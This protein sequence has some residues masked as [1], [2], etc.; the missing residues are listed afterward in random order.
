[1][2]V[3]DTDGAFLGKEDLYPGDL[4]F[5]CETAKGEKH[6]GVALGMSEMADIE[7]AAR[8]AQAAAWD[9]WGIGGTASAMYDGEFVS[10]GVNFPWGDRR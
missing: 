9:R 10:Y 1:M 3:I 2:I 7:D 6:V 8:V 4:T 5:K